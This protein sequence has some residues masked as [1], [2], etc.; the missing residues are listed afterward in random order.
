MIQG[1]ESADNLLRSVKARLGMR[2]GAKAWRDVHTHYPAIVAYLINADEDDPALRMDAFDELMETLKRRV[3][4]FD[5][6]DLP[7]EDVHVFDD[8]LSDFY[9]GKAS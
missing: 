6:G 3:D 8:L 9:Y 1:Q 2:Q 4:G 5:V 7:L